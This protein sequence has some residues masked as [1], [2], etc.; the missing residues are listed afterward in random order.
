M[1]GQ[2]NAHN[3]R[4]NFSSVGHRWACLVTKQFPALGME[5]IAGQHF[6]VTTYLLGSSLS[7]SS[8]C[9]ILAVSYEPVVP[10]SSSYHVARPSCGFGAGH[11]GAGCEAGSC[12]VRTFSEASPDSG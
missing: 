12:A 5:G 1:V 9:D 11:L 7:S 6:L 3:K 10:C 2:S 8:G 4:H